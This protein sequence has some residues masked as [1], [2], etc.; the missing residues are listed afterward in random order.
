MYAKKST[1]KPVLIEKIALKILASQRLQNGGLGTRNLGR[2]SVFRWYSPKREHNI[3]LLI[4]IGAKDVEPKFYFKKM[5]KRIIVW[6]KYHS[7]KIVS[8]PSSRQ[9][10]FSGFYRVTLKLKNSHSFFILLNFKYMT[11]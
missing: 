11:S 9:G 5:K 10:H 8:A 2:V 4:V 3:I 6:V 1:E 7:I